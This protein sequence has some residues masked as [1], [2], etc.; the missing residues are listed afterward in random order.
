MWN[1]RL[2]ATEVWFFLIFN[3]PIW[4][5]G[6]E[7][8]PQ[9]VPWVLVIREIWGV[10]SLLQI[11]S[12]PGYGIWAW[13]S[14]LLLKKTFLTVRAGAR[15]YMSL[16][17]QS[18]ALDAREAYKHIWEMPWFLY[19][20]R[21]PLNLSPCS[22]AGIDMSIT[23]KNP[24]ASGQEGRW[25]LEAESTLIQHLCEG[26]CSFKRGRESLLPKENCIRCN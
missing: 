6:T 18:L 2:A 20:I 22:V 11:A 23:G 17:Y 10:F 9:S 15:H 3:H 14:S 16:C 26:T 13:Y 25:G 21:R 8:V 12:L 24:G 5:N 19:A 4:I 1:R 7:S